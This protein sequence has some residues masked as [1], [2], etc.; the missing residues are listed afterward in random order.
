MTSLLG[1]ALLLITATPPQ[2]LS[3]IRQAL[4]KG[5]LQQAEDALTQAIAQHPQDA[6]IQRLLGLLRQ[7]QGRPQ[8][9]A[10]AFGKALGIDPADIQASL[11]LSRLL[12]QQ[13]QPAQAA[14]VLNEAIKQHPA[15][16]RLLYQMG[17]LAA[18]AGRLDEALNQLRQIPEDQAPDG[19]WETI[20]RLMATRADFARAEQAYL[21]VL[22]KHPDS[23]RALRTLSGLALK[24]ERTEEAWRYIAQ[25]RT[26]APYSPDVLYDFAQVSLLHGLRAEAV[27]AARLLRLIAPDRSDYLFLLGRALLND[28]AAE[29]R[30]LF[31]QYVERE[32]Q[33][34]EGRMML[35]LARYL[36]GE[37]DSARQ[38]LEAA[39]RMNPG[40][41]EVHY[42][43]GMVAY[44]MAQNEEAEQQLFQVIQQTPNHGLARLGL[45]KIY[46][47]QGKREEALRELL[48]ASRLLESDSEVRFQL[49]R[50]YRDMGDLEKAQQELEAYQRLK[51]RE[52]ESNRRA[53]ELPF[54]LGGGKNQ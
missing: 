40:L 45:G 11:D 41:A 36:L 23:I 2:D 13:K 28:D 12:Q 3:A 32:P 8:D 25:A 52:E 47:R 19:Y 34:D 43:L 46:I 15:E 14:K 39:L 29:A 4:E 38:D 26:Q 33:S 51:K 48:Q 50:V 7:Q 42:Y 10:A 20:G 53:A 54:I 44:K 24:Q 16:P 17:L 31:E 22:E 27:G 5:Q 30:I 9:A 37:L 35:G 18:E 49:S 21:R 6:E 1:I